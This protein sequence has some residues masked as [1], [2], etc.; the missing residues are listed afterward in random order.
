ME[1]LG[2]RFRRLAKELGINVSGERTINP[3]MMNLTIRIKYKK[4][5]KDFNKIVDDLNEISESK[6]NDSLKEELM[7]AYI[8][9][10]GFEVSAEIKE[11]SR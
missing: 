4:C 6:L 5:E 1:T 9:K 10:Y 7:L 3:V 2:D 11:E 8:R